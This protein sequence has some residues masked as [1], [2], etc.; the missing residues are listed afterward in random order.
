VPQ[1]PGN[2]VGGATKA[3]I[4]KKRAPTKH[5]CFTGALIALRQKIYVVDAKA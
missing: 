2:K 1:L 3:P 5:C 4:Y